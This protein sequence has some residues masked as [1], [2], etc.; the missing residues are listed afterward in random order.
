MTAQ[1]ASILV[2]DDE[3]DVASATAEWLGLHGYV[4]HIAGAAAAALAFIREQ[5]VDIIVSDLRMPGHD[6]TWLLNN[7][8][9]E[10]AKPGFIM[11]TGHGDVPA[12]VEAMQLGAEDFLE[13]P[14]DP[15]HLLNVVRR[16]EEKNWMRAELQRL[17][18]QLLEQSPL[19][20]FFPADNAQS[21]ET[22]QQ[23]TRLAQMDAHILLVGEEGT[24]R[25]E[26]A[27]ALHEASER[28]QGPLTNLSGSLLS[29]REDALMALFGGTRFADPRGAV[30][31]A[32]G[33]AFILGEPEKLH[34]DAAQLLSMAFSEGQITP[35]GFDTPFPIDARLIM[36]T[37]PAHEKA[38]RDALR[39][40]PAP[41]RFELPPIRDRLDDV[42]ALFASL[43]AKHAP[44][45]MDM[46]AITP[47][48]IA[49][50]LEYD[51]P[52][53]MRELEQIAIAHISGLDLGIGEDTDDRLDLDLRAKVNRFECQIIRATLASTGGNQSQA[54]RLLK[55]PRRT[56]G[57]RMKRLGLS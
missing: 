48:T 40:S 28:R 32:A 26:L 57:E 49:R 29:E 39:I 41:A 9:D 55:I 52:G 43:A 10:P 27:K 42:P 54:A 2:V 23:L 47:D 44:A 53:N 4:T 30:R 12:A 5:A 50:L 7:I 16:V 6:G 35:P 34:P 14:Y 15:V 13:K 24:G 46:P 56:L 25:A 3:I 38:V 1:K 31:D 37:L 33:G 21:R 19:R 20:R 11:L 17:Q 22:A 51:W 8:Q 18:Q 36:W 45:E